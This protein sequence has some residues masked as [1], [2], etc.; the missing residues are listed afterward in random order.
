MNTVFPEALSSWTMPEIRR[1]FI[2]ATGITRRPSRMAG[3]ASASSTPSAT[4]L[5]MTLRM[6]ELTDPDIADN[7]R[8][9]AASSGEALSRISP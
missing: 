4:A 7:C 8:R 6:A 5:A 9:M 3:A 1:L 2:G